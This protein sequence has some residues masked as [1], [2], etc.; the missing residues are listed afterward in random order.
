MFP[1]EKAELFPS[2][3]TQKARTK[4]FKKSFNR[5]YNISFEML[6]AQNIE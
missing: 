6:V 2:F 3:R 5:R 4:T 1:S